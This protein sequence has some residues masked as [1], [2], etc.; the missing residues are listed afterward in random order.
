MTGQDLPSMLFRHPVA[1][2]GS[3]VFDL[4]S[5]CPPL[6][7]NSRYCNLLQCTHFS[8]TSVAVFKVQADS[9]VGSDESRTGCRLVGFLSAYLM[10]EQSDTLFLWQ[11][12]VAGEARGQGL[13]SR[14]I[15]YLLGCRCCSQVRFIET[16]VT[17][18]NHSSRQVFEKLASGLGAPLHTKPCFE[19]HLHFDGVHDSEILIRIGPFHLP[20]AI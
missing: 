2:D 3:A 7:T 8:Q 16:T 10:P 19:K 15:N 12:A 13:A 20:H 17:A 5:A 11:M 9:G 4:I 1:T 14:M 6:D 18:T